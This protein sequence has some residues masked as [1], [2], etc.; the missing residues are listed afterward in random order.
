MMHVSR[1]FG[2]TVDHDGRIPNILVGCIMINTYPNFGY[3]VD[4]N[5]R[6]PTTWVHSGSLWTYAQNMG[7]HCI[8]MDVY[9]KFGYI[10]PHV[11]HIY[12]PI[13]GYMVHH[14][15]SIP[16]HW[17]YGDHDGRTQKI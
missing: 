5:G 13:F 8:T 1:K 4:H 16:K 17:V 15:G 9:P 11:G 12:Y 7:R 10:V 6:I 14:D 3:M 2:Y